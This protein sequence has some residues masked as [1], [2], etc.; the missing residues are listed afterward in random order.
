M[1][2][3]SAT[4]F[5]H[6]TNTYEEV[7][8]EQVGAAIASGQYTASGATT[9]T[10]AEGGLVTRPV[11]QLG[12][13]GVQGESS[14]EGVNAARSAAARREVQRELNSD[15]ALS[16]SEGLVDALTLGIIHQT[17]EQADLRR[18]ADSGT[19]L[20]G[21]LLGTAAGL[22]LPG[23]V[24]GVT[25]GGEKLGESIARALLG[26]AQTGFKGVV[27][28]GL[29]EAG[30][31]AAL[32]SA[33][34]FGHQITDAVVANKP[35]AAESILH[36]A[37]VGA[38]LGFGFGFAGSAFGQAANASRSAVEASGVAVKESRAAL[39]S[40]DKLTRTWD[41]AVEQ[42]AQRVGVLR[43][44]ADEG[45]VSAGAMEQRASA[46]AK[47][48]KA[49]DALRAIDAERALGGDAKSFQKWRDAVER[50]QAA[51]TELDTSMTPSMVERASLTPVVPGARIHPDYMPTGAAAAEG[52]E[53][54]ARAVGAVPRA[55]TLGMA[56]AGDRTSWKGAFNK[57]TPPRD[58]SQVLDELMTPEKRAAYE[59]LHGRPFEEAPPS[60]VAQD[61]HEANLGG[62]S[63]PT[64][65]QVTTPGTAPRRVVQADTPPAAQA[66][67]AN[68]FANTTNRVAED[69]GSGK[70]AVK[71][72]LNNWFKEYDAK[73]RVK[74]GDQL[75]TELNSAIDNIAK[76]S[77]TRLDSAGG[78]AL[79]KSL[80]LKE[81]T[82]P[83]GQRLDQVW[84]LGQA[85]KFAADEARGVK[86]PLRT[87]LMNVLRGHGAAGVV[88]RYELRKLGRKVGGVAL[89]GALGGPAGA[90][91]GHA[92]T[93]AGFAGSVASSAGKLMQQVSVAGEALLRGR[94]ATLA[95]RT[96]L[97]N[98][99][100][101]YSDDGPIKD[102]VQRILEVQR[103][104][105]NPD[106]IRARVTR[107]VGDLTITSP[108]LAQ[109]LIESTV[110]QIS[111]ISAAAPAIMMTP[112]GKPL[113]PSGTALTRF[114][115]FEN[116]MHDLPGILKSV[117]A[118]QAT[119]TQIKALHVGFPAVHE[120]L[121][122]EVMGGSQALDK[123]SEAKLKAVEKVLGVPLT[124]S[125]TDPTVTARLQTNWHAPQPVQQP[126]QSFKINS[127]KPTPVQ[128]S[129]GD[130]APGNERIAR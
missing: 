40:V 129:S 67:T 26:E 125:S 91:I 48:D 33:G 80:G 57:E 51:V 27:T 1:A 14:A 112:T 86:T 18:E 122:R 24:R 128:A 130:R 95:V 30:A 69:A 76:S 119:T 78:L 114:L 120:E 9:T 36:E 110:R 106:A 79:P 38:L 12:A 64:S 46:L 42:H 124:R 105:A 25:T 37:G 5:N 99:P 4:L 7:P 61:V 29:Q 39:E 70:R 74:L 28:R 82:S 115:A 126:A 2:G 15:K 20:L 60:P 97:G 118:G 100:Y 123:L 72:Y 43:V 47:A 55:D 32:M 62:K 104:A 111:A 103:L 6:Q 54:M 77:G 117:A 107:E 56:A 35:F 92:L 11:E 8:A 63:T 108:E 109:H 116:A 16:L 96:A 85:G 73:P 83:L 68:D 13:A 41:E 98:R 94:R 89:G 17:G 21:Q 23:P 93:S 52:Q 90:L 22:K 88:E 49:R 59:Q 127:P 50:Y 75:Q 44:L 87:S 53:L 19:F 71:D 101:Q 65:D 34:A 102:P 113:P 31:S 10:Q 3:P 58:P 45:H 66:E 121:V 84:S 81:A